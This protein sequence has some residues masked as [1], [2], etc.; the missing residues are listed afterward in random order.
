MIIAVG[1]NLSLH[2]K[3]KLFSASRLQMNLAGTNLMMH[4]FFLPY[5]VVDVRGNYL[6]EKS[7]VLA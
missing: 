5:C 6:E 4:R 1:D 2:I 7:I 3:R